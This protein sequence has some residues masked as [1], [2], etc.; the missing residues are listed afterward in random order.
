M[1]PIMYVSIYPEN[2][3]LIAG[4]VIIATLLAGLYPAWR[5]GRV[6]PVDAIKLV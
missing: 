1:D 6:A 2:A 4:V 5:A 3:V